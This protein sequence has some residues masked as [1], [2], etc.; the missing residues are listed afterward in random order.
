MSDQSRRRLMANQFTLALGEALGGLIPHE[1]ISLVISFL[2]SGR[3]SFSGP[4]NPRPQEH[5]SLEDTLLP[6]NHDPLEREARA[7]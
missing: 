2:T 6:H 7:D 1:S 5:D 3:D 4:I